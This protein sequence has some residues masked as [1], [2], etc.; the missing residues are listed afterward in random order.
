MKKFMKWAGIVLGCLI[1]VGFLGFLYFIPPF[2]LAPPEEF[3]GP[4]AS[5]QPSL[6]GIKDPAQRAIAEHGK[7]IVLRTGC[8]ECH[9]PQG[10]KGPMWDQYL[11]G[12]M[13]LNSKESG[14]VISRNLTSD[15]QT[16][17]ARRTDADV[18]RVLRSG[19][20]SDGRLVNHRAMPWAPFSNWSEEDRYAVLTFLRNVKPFKHEIPEPSQEVISGKPSEKE[21]F[22]VGDFAKH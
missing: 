12:G 8:T 2:T 4:P 19:V 22:I 21:F 15:L 20:L 5:A 17:L 1:V 10:D 11:A 13:K 14:T 3:S 9:T 7:Y 6:G 16:G 18:M